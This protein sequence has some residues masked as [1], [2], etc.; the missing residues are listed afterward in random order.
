VNDKNKKVKEKCVVARV[1][2]F[3]PSGLEAMERPPTD[4]CSAVQCS[5]VQCSAVQCSAGYTLALSL[6][7]IGCRLFRPR[8]DGISTSKDKSPNKQVSFNQENL[9]EN[10]VDKIEKILTEKLTVGQDVLEKQLQDKETEAEALT[11]KV[12]NFKEVQ[13]QMAAEV[14]CVT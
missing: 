7:C 4:R 12:K 9:I 8:E 2:L 11:E 14:P 1:L 3:L 13:D 6:N 10:K 5:A